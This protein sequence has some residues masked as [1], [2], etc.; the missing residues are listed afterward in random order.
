MDTTRIMIPGSSD[1][2]RRGGYK[3]EAS[4]MRQYLEMKTYDT[5]KAFWEDHNVKDLEEH[6]NMFRT[7][8]SIQSVMIKRQMTEL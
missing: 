5:M 8:I 1:D 7:S 6:L 4:K 2:G 3:K